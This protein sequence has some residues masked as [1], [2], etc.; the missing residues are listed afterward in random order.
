MARK[1][2][3]NDDCL[4]QKRQ[5][6][7]NEKKYDIDNVIKAVIRKFQQ[8]GV[9]HGGDCLQRFLPECSFEVKN[10]GKGDKKNGLT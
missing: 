2:I 10:H 8:S 5:H 4:I 7:L 9:W 1:N 3:L 6:L